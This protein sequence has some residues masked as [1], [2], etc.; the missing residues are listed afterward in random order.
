M[1]LRELLA[2]MPVT[3]VKSGASCLE[4]EIRGVTK[5]SREVREGYVFFA[6]GTSKPFLEKALDLKAT[7]IVS[8][9]LPREYSLSGR[10]GERAAAPRE[11]GCQVL[12]I[13]LPG[14][15]RNGCNR[16]ERK[17]HDNLSHR[18]HCPCFG[19][20]C[21]RCRHHLLP[22]RR[23]RAKGPEHDPRICGD[24]SAFAGHVGWGVDHVV[25]EV[26]SHALDQGRVE[27]VDFDCAIF[28]NLT[29]D[30][31]D[32]HGDFDH[33][34]RA[35][36]L[37]FHRYLRQSAKERK[38][39]IINIDDASAPYFIPEPPVKTLTYSTLTNAD[40]YLTSY[41]E[42]I[43]GLSLGLSVQ[44]RQL[45]LSSPLLGFFNASNILA[46]VLFGLTSDFPLEAIHRGV[47][48]LTGVP[49]RLQ[50]VPADRPIH[51][52][53]DYAHTPDALRKTI[54]TLN[55]VRSGRLIVVFGCG[56]DRD[57]TKR[58]MMG[59]IAS[60][61]ADIVV[62]TSDNPRGEEPMSIIEQIRSGITGK[63]FTIIENG[64]SQA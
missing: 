63:P 24:P 54:E 35:K 43:S 10:Y 26:S 16:H 47:E 7:A 21:R 57:R 61:L 2:D 19:R 25:M 60:E 31:L 1:T 45:A 29:H 64:C 44:G 5:D 39:A 30:H 27:D 49:G 32:Y 9:D 23:L 51:I 8:D 14:N 13:P 17:D 41:H 20:K 18:V 22:V 15:V 3:T 48:T 58:P 40:A 33:Y 46:A 50:K 28:T 11:D 42:D 4:Q 36:A 56:G 38:Y 53:V 12:R 6:T 62:I 52:F 34:R 55:R 37:L 59:R